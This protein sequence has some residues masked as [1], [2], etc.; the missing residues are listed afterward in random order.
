[1]KSAPDENV[2]N[3]KSAIQVPFDIMQLDY[4]LFAF[5]KRFLPLLPSYDACL[6]LSEQ[7]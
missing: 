3:K 1:M 6:D 2:T 4:Q 5:Q 7:P